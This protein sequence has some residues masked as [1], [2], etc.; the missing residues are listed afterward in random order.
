[1]KRNIFLSFKPEFF[2]PILYGIK[3]YEYRK[4]FCKEKV[5]AYLYLS[6]PVHEVIG[7]MELGEPL[8]IGE[9]IKSVDNNS[10]AYRRLNNCLDNREQYAIPIESLK[11]YKTPV[12]ISK[13]KKINPDFFVP[14]SYLNIENHSNIFEFLNDQEMYTKEFHHEH[15]DIYID[16]IGATCKEMEM[17]DEFKVKDKEYTSEKKYD[18]IKSGYLTRREK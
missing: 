17:S 10:L 8:L 7:V 14:H 12:P 15:K 1:M 3:K 2:R 11:L 9:V 4:R 13:I 6:S 18:I 5:R 16:N